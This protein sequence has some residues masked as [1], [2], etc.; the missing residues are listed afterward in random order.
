MLARHC[1][2]LVLV[3]GLVFAC[4]AG[5]V[6]VG[7]SKRAAKPA[8]GPPPAA[9]LQGKCEWSVQDGLL[10]QAGTDIS[11]VFTRTKKADIDG[12]PPL[13]RTTWLGDCS[14]W[15]ECLYAALVRCPDGRFR[16]VWGPDYAW[17][18]KDPDVRTQPKDWA[19]LIF[20][21]RNREA[22]CEAILARRSVREGEAWVVG[23]PCLYTGKDAPA[24]NEALCGN[25]KPRA[26]KP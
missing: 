20:Y 14:N 5:P 4:A 9:H 24:W 13:D 12:M 15:N 6:P 18:G 11:A 3:T 2:A 23:P 8:L 7:S 19:E 16:A 10:R 26:C 17:A 21:A 25:D 22:G 1:A